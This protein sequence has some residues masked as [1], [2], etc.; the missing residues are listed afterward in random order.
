MAGFWFVAKSRAK[1]NFFQYL[2]YAADVL[3][4]IVQ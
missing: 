1:N 4:D 2:F 3:P